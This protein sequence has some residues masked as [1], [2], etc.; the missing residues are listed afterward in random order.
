MSDILSHLSSYGKQRRKPLTFLY[1]NLGHYAP[2]KKIIFK[3]KEQDKIKG[4]NKKGTEKK[5]QIKIAD[6]IQ[7][8]A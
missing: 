7:W 6:F 3:E 1:Q 4:T 5:E 8:E 2:Q